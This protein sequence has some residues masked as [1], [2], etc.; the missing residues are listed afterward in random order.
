MRRRV[1]LA[2]LDVVEHVR[3]MVAAIEAF[4]HAS[5]EPIAAVKNGRSAGSRS[6]CAAFEFFVRRNRVFSLA[7]EELRERVL[8]VPQQMHDEPL[9]PC[10][11]RR[12]YG[13]AFEMQTIQRRGAM[14]HWV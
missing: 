6:P 4:E 14:L 2:G 11:Q 9:R 8:I 10:T 5:G 3:D 7:A 13:F 1:P 12:T